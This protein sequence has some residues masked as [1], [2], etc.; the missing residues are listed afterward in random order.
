MKDP[1]NLVLRVDKSVD[2][3]VVLI[4]TVTARLQASERTRL[5]SNRESASARLFTLCFRN[6]LQG[7]LQLNE[8]SFT[9]PLTPLESGSSAQPTAP[10]D[11]S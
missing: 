9:R 1:S 6:I 5:D 3:E 8:T 2:V 11:Q 7:P 10:A 4:G